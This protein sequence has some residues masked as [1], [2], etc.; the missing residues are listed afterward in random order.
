MAKLYAQP[1]SG[2]CV[3]KL[4]DGR[5]HVLREVQPPSGGC[6][7]KQVFDARQI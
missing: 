5:R 2:G 1:P 6:V 4:T 3:L 7:L